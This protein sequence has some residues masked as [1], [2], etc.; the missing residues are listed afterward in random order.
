MRQEARR[1]ASDPELLRRAM[2]TFESSVYARNSAT[3]RM[4]RLRLWSD[5]AS[6]HFP[7]RDPF[8]LTPEMI[9]KTVAVLNG[10]GYRSAVT[11]LSGAKQQHI[12]DGHPW[13]DRL[14]QAARSANR[15]SRRGLGPPKH[16][17]PFPFARAGELPD[18]A[19]PW[20]KGGPMGPR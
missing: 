8:F 4:E 6:A 13:T 3:P 18:G 14:A 11:I 17:A 10:A 20:A 19:D 1:I 2:D 5:I 12:E 15:A 16:S 7:D 9:F